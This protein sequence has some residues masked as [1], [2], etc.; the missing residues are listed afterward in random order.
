[1]ATV[2]QALHGGGEMDLAL[3]NM[4]GFFGCTRDSEMPRHSARAYFDV[5]LMSVWQKFDDRAE[6][7]RAIHAVERNPEAIRREEP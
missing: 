3:Q 5:R 1:M 2:W 7:L 6:V 4:R